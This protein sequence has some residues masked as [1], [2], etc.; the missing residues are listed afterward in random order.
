MSS[1]ENLDHLNG[2]SSD[3][4]IGALVGAGLGAAL[5]Y[6]LDP[7]RG[8]M[9]RTQL[10]DQVAS[11]A[12]KLGD[13][14]DAKTRNLRNRAHGLLHEVGLLSQNKKSSQFVERNPHTGFSK[15]SSG[16]PTVGAL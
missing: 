9:R 4:W 10:S 8:R 13:A 3:R 14:L 11:I 16:R 7:D 15:G 6:L 2:G 1:T 5:M 12:N